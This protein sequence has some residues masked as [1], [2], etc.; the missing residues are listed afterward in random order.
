MKMVNGLAVLAV[1]VVALGCTKSSQSLTPHRTPT[2]S[3][4][5]AGEAGTWKELRSL[6]VERGYVCAISDGDLIY[7]IGGVG[8]SDNPQ[9]TA[10]DHLQF[11][12][13]RE[14]MVRYQPQEPD[15]IDI[16]RIGSDLPVAV[17]GAACAVYGNKIFVMGGYTGEQ[18]HH[19]NS[20]VLQVFDLSTSSWIQGPN[21]NEARAWGAAVVVGDRICVVGGVGKG[22]SDTVECYDPDDSGWQKV[23]QISQGRYGLGAIAYDDKIYVYGGDY[24]QD[25]IDHN[26][27]TIEQF[28]LKSGRSE[29]VGHI[30]EATSAIIGIAGP[31]GRN[32]LYIQGHIWDATDPTKLVEIGQV[33]ASPQEFDRVYHGFAYPAVTVIPDGIVILG[34]GGSGAPSNNVKVLCTK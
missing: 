32:Y 3:V 4:C 10:D 17:A 5:K 34:G 20:N 26:L 25:N 24:W 2:L 30:S 14:T 16:R 8:D 33:P 9:T 19:Q 11:P 21:M 18:E 23:G 29:I 1:A 6:P 15:N 13:P 28:D 31:A 22:Y 12:Q 7:V 27:D